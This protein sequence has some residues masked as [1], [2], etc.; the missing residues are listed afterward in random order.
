MTLRKW[1]NTGKWKRKHCITLWRTCF[2]KGY[3]PVIGQTTEWTN[4]WMNEW[5]YL[6]RYVY[7]LFF[8]QFPIPSSEC[9]L[10]TTTKQNAKENYYDCCHVVLVCVCVRA[11]VGGSCVFV[12]R[13]KTNKNWSFFQ[14]LFPKIIL[15]PKIIWR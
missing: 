10:L 14:G 13:K 2:W 4:E 1:Q 8:N 9:S 5:M 15:R 3:G 12:Y 6:Y 7:G 11:R